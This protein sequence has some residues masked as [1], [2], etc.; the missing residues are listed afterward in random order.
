M[1]VP[2]FLFLAHFQN[3]QDFFMNKKAQDIHEN[4]IQ[5]SRTKKISFRSFQN[6]QSV[7]W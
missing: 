5:F 1:I 7:T 6:S 2:T 3:Y 4:N